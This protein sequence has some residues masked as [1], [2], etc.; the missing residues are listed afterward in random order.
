MMKRPE[1]NNVSRA[2]DGN[3]C[4]VFVAGS[5]MR[6]GGWTSNESTLGFTLLELLL[7]V[8]I[9]GIVL[10]AI[11]TVFFSAMRLRN[12][13]VAAIQEALPLQQTLTLIKHDLQGLVVP[14]TIAG[15]L[16]TV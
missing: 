2:S 12:K 6:C 15:A 4:R 9:F 10:A 3:G 14:G 8:A 13:T 7:A 5:R 16:Q 11:N 1:Q